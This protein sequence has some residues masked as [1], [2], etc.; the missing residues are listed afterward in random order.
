M[1]GEKL[2]IHLFSHIFLGSPP[3]ARGKD[4]ETYSAT[5]YGRI[6]P[7]CAGKSCSSLSQSRIDWDHP[8]M[9]GEKALKYMVDSEHKGSPPHA[10]GK[11]LGHRQALD[12]PR[13]TPACAGKRPSEPR[14]CR[15]RRDHPRMRGEKFQIYISLKQILGSPP[16]A[17]GKE[18]KSETF[19]FRTRITPACAGKRIRNRTER[20]GRGDHPRM[21]GEKCTLN[22]VCM[23]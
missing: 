17:R 15:W 10:R 16:H 21:R 12:V 6:T 14:W 7:A 18:S 8:R 2:C 4:G 23:L 9:R 22:S 19:H 20:R 11:V 5:S 13:I 3:H 1:R